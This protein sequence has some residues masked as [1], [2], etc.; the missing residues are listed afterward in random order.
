MQLPETGLMTSGIPAGTLVVPV[1]P[2]Q[3]GDRNL[4]CMSSC[5]CQSNN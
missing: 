5:I 4:K 3:V 2:D 1:H